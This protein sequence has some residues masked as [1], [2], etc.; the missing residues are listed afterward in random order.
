MKISI[1]GASGKVGL[2]VIRLLSEQND[3]VDPITVILYSPNNTKKVFGYLQDLEESLIVRNKFFAKNIYFFPTSNMQ[4]VQHSDLIIVTAG[5]FATKEEKDAMLLQDISGRDIQSN[6]NLLL[7]CDICNNLKE[8]SPLSHIVIVTNQVDIMSAKAREILMT[9]RIYGLGCYIDTIR[10]KNILV[11]EARKNNILLNIKDIQANILGYHNNY[12][13][14]DSNNFRINCDV[15]KIFELLDISIKKTILRGKEISDLQKDVH[16]PQLNSGSSKL[17]AAALFNIIKSYTQSN[18]GLD[19]PLNRLLNTEEQ[20]R[21]G[22]LA[23]PAAQLLCKITHNN[24]EALTTYLASSD[25][26]KIKKGAKDIDGKL[27]TL[28]NNLYK[29]KGKE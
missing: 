4:L 7:I 6:K 2:E 18:Q 27:K 15:E 13:F 11:Q 23:H 26:E 12:L 8:I 16:N 3:F 20:N 19:I 21:L 25:I 1:I 10:F 5:L 24:I 14:L 17:P 29:S 28:T 9:E 22:E